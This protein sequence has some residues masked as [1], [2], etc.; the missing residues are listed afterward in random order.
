M[1]CLN[2]QVPDSHGNS[3]MAY[4]YI[5]MCHRKDY[6]IC[7]MATLGWGAK[8]FFYFSTAGPIVNYML[9]ISII[10]M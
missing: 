6:N 2:F 4:V 8:A 10:L 5:S 1:R 7:D 3:F 9:T